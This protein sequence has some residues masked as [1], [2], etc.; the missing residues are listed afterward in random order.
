MTVLSCRMCTFISWFCFKLANQKA[1]PEQR[2][3][4]LSHYGMQS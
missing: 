2:L 1:N 4:L 3:T